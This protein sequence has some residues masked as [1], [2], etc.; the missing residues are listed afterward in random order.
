MGTL[1]VC[2]LDPLSNLPTQIR[3]MMRERTYREKSLGLHNS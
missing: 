1:V 3:D 2:D